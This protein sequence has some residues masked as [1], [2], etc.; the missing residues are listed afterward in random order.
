MARQPEVAGSI[1]TAMLIT[2]AMIEGVACWPWSCAGEVVASERH[3]QEGE[4][5]DVEPSLSF[6]CCVAIGLAMAAPVLAAAPA[7]A[8]KAV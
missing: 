2:A 4:R 8:A 1:Q 6:A 5:Y 3:L 7:T